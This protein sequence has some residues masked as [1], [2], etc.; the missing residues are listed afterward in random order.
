MPLVIHGLGVDTHMHTYLHESDFKKT[1]AS[2]RVPGL[3]FSTFLTIWH[4]R[5]YILHYNNLLMANRASVSCVHTK[6]CQCC[7]H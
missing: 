3:K 5:N 2:Q 4:I 6:Q 1:G 7:G